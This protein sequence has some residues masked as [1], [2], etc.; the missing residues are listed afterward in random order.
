MDNPHPFII[1]H[2][3]ILGELFFLS[4]EGIKKNDDI[5]DVLFVDLYKNVCFN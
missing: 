3:I 2:I 4:V 1:N 5:A